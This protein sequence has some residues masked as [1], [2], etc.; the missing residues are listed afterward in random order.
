MNELVQK[1]I[2]QERKFQ[3][4]SFGGPVFDDLL[5]LEDWGSLILRHG[6]LGMGHTTQDT[7]DL[8]RFYKQMI[9]VGAIAVAAA[10]ST[11]RKMSKEKIAGPTEE[12]LASWKGY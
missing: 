6:G 10:E 9:R 7:V 8:Q 12:Q 2:E 4:E 11:I 3:D 5:H 1:A